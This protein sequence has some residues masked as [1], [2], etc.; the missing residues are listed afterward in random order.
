M[1]LNTLPSVI[2]QTPAVLAFENEDPT[3]SKE[4][5]KLSD[6]PHKV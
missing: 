2:T 4:F 1:I 5:H 3:A 6:E